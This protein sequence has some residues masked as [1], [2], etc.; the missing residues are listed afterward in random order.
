M[1]VALLALGVALGGTSYAAVSLPKN[2]VGAAQIKKDAVTS[3]KIRDDAV[4]AAKIKPGQ[5]PAGP[6]GP[7]G[8]PGPQGPAGAKGD[9][10]PK[11]DTGAPATALWAVVAGDGTIARGSHVTSV[12]AAGAFYDVAFD[13]NVSACAFVAA[14][15]GADLEGQIGHVSASR[16][17][18]NVNGVHVVTFD[19]AGNWAAGS[20]HLAVFC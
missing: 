2:S 14:R 7:A 16:Q 13:R 18:G 8:P 6:R 17:Q 15:G 4:T 11:G 5:L 1:V 12:T 20:F 10:G 3:S 19:L 9:A